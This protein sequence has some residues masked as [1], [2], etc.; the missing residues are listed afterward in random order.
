MSAAMAATTVEQ[1]LASLSADRR[2]AIEQVR[3]VVNAN[4]PAG[5]EEGIEFG[6]IG[7]YIP[8]S[9]YPD[10]YNKRPIGIAALASQKQY[11]ALYL[12]SVYGDPKLESW[13]KKAFA[14]AGK[15]L[16]MGKSCVRF[17]TVDALP[18]DV[19]GETIAK[20]PVDAFIAS[21]EKV[22]AKTAKKPS[23]RIVRAA[24]TKSKPKAKPKAK[25]KAKAKPKR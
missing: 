14:A 5:Y 4:L 10:T 18:L 7:W 25:A 13:F 17:R 12:T 8:L 21:Y 20:V 11:M 9:R 23:P 6:M 24:R 2:A 16:D 22:R 19:I 15:K 3:S 1:Y